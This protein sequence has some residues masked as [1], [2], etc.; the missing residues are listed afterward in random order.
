M[1][2]SVL[3]VV[4]IFFCLF[5]RDKDLEPQLETPNHPGEKVRKAGQHGASQ[6]VGPAE[7]GSS[8]DEDL[9]QVRRSQ[10]LLEML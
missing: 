2:F 9:S 4:Y 6:N 1:V 10:C 3:F 5:C 7:R 8:W